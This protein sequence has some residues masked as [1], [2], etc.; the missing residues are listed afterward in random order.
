MEN[1][2]NKNTAP[3]VWGSLASG[4]TN[5]VRLLV[6]RILRLVSPTFRMILVQHQG[7][8]TMTFRGTLIEITAVVSSKIEATVH[9]RTR[10]R[11]V[12]CTCSVWAVLFPEKEFYHGIFVWKPRSTRKL[13]VEYVSF[14][15][16]TWIKILDPEIFPKSRDPGWRGL[17]ATSFNQDIGSWNGFQSQFYV[18]HVSRFILPQSFWFWLHSAY[19]IRDV[20]RVT[21]MDQEHWLIH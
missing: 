12:L 2:S 20:F 11:T 21:D 9:A 18:E 14:K 5:N 3:T 6:A 19:W 10:F 17:S 7:E 8:I 15:Q 1:T 4:P 16:L 13:H